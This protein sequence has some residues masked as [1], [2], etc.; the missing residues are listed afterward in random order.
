MGKAYIRVRRAVPRH[1]RAGFFKGD[2]CREA[3]GAAGWGEPT[4]QGGSAN[5]HFYYVCRR[6]G[7]TCGS[8]TR[9]RRR[10]KCLPERSRTLGKNCPRV[11]EPHV[12]ATPS[13]SNSAFRM[14]RAKDLR[15]RYEAEAKERQKESGKC[16]GRGK[17][18]ENLPQPIPGARSR[19]ALGKQFGI[20][21]RTAENNSPQPH[22]RP[23]ATYPDISPIRPSNA[24]MRH[25]RRFW[26]MPWFFARK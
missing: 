24:Q 4:Q 6:C 22:L 23:S 19:D 26:G 15:K 16:H 14:G 2:M 5:L 25:L 18:V 12:P 1:R 9:T 11:Q 7:R 8:G 13:G 10:K 3:G 20:S 17:V 21:G